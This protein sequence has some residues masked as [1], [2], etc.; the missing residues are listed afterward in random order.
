MCCVA[1]P[2]TYN[3]HICIS[4]LMCCCPGDYYGEGKVRKKELL[5]SAAILG[6]SGTHVRIVNDS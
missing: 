6:I 4:Y 3:M 2:D 5:H 1:N